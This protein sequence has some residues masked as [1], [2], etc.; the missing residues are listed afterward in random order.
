MHAI[1]AISVFAS[2]ALCSLSLGFTNNE[3]DLANQ[4]FNQMNVELKQLNHEAAEQAWESSTLPTQTAIV[5]KIIKLTVRKAHWERMMCNRGQRYRDFNASFERTLHLLCR[6]LRH[7]DD[8]ISMTNLLGYLQGIY[9]GTQVCVKGSCDDDGKLWQSTF[10]KYP[11]LESGN[12]VEPT[13]NEICLFG[14]PDMERIMTGETMHQFKQA[15]NCMASDE[16]ILD[17]AWQ[18]W[19]LAVGPPVKDSYRQLI[20]VMNVGAR[21]SGYQD[22]GEA[23]RAELEMPNLRGIVN[24]LW[25][26]V[27]PLYQKLHAVMRNFL[28]KRHP[29]VTNFH[30]AGPIPAHLLGDMWSQNWDTY[31]A[32]MFPHEV[33]IESNFRRSNCSAEKMVRRAEDFYSSMGL[34]MM[35]ETFWRK[36][37][38][39]RTE[40]VTK[41]H[42]TAANMYNAGDFRMIACA[43]NAMS[44]FYVILHEM[45]HIIYYMLASNQPTIFQEGTNS[46]FQETIGDTIHIA[47]LTP[48]HLIRLGLLNSSY[49]KPDSDGNLNH[50]DYSL[51][52]KI[53]LTKI[54]ALPFSYL[55]DSYRWSLF[56]GSIKFEIEAN[57]YFW[58]LL[59]NEQGIQ[60]ASKTNRENL[61]DAAAK[62]HFPDNTPYVRYFLA[63]FLS[64]QI[65]EGLCKKSIFGDVRTSQE[66][67]LPLHR[68]DL[69]GS[70][71]AGRLLEKALKLGGSQHWTFVLEIL[72]GSSE[73]SSRPL[74]NYFAP[75]IKMLDSIISD[76]KLPVGW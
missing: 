70:K 62:Y 36:S 4:W 20:D 59:E 3:T 14:E 31:A 37:I 6:S 47:A 32:S 54:P 10:F 72:T 30:P 50:F 67:P 56:D 66:L 28:K 13:T 7:T 57:N 51:L 52:L 18:S 35:T 2:I 53:G 61:F 76:L 25:L 58:Y 1:F 22:I 55:M 21:R 24:R 17:W 49:L 16:K 8:E 60:S 5:E 68:C 64:F 73:I 27:K 23:W 45:G 65:L 40:N 29:E 33:D 19:R 34:P 15:A 44:D 69:Y 63:N 48:S 39:K 9:T 71:R 12:Y 74:M 42:G 43:G 26:E 46:A 11:E 38:F 41:C 75:L